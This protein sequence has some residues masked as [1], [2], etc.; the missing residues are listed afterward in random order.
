MDPDPAERWIANLA[1]ALHGRAGQVQAIHCGHLH[2]PLVTRFCGIP[3]SVTPSVAP[4]VALDLRPIDGEQPDGRALITTEAP[5]YALHH[6]D[7]T[8]LATH[9]ERAGDG[10]VCV[11]CV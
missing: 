5:G 7:G 2:R 1:A 8:R 4:L 3:L 11:V 6:W 10:D 9:Y